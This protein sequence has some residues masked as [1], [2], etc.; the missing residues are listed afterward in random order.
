MVQPRAYE[1]LTGPEKAAVF[2]LAA[3]PEH[4]RKVFE[5]LEF[6][7]IREITQAM[8]SL[9]LIPG[10]VVEAALREFGERCGQTGTLIG[11]Y[12]SAERLL[13][14]FLDEDK[15]QIIME[16][17]RG[18]AGRTLWD[19]LGNVNEAVLAAYL[20]NEYP[21]TIAVVLSKVKPEHAARVLSVLPDEIA[22]E[23][24]MRM[25]RME[26]VQKEIIKEVEK[27]LRAEFMTNLARTHGRDNHEVMAEI[28][29]YLDRGTE[30]RLI[31]MLEERNKES[32][33]KVRAAMFTFEDL[34]RLD[35][36]GIQTLLRR[37]DQSKLGIALKGASEPVR[38]LFF[39]NMSERAAKL[40][41]DDM[42][43]AGPVRVRDVEDAQMAMIGLAKDLAASGEIYL[44]ET[45]EE[46]M[47]Y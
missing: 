42:E 26:V 15:V 45:K 25:L 39:A 20:K 18:P 36:A 5:R 28:F 34:V 43:M 37:A 13:S 23:S 33:D 19:K 8:S 4:A 11:S 46:E 3:G 16:E 40:L 14:R 2:M 6:D 12:E 30:T 38:E 29:N 32:A 41:R 9:G 21:Q 7:E 22:I 44:A 17:I 47:I 31:E 35:A 10:E 24:V 1:S 27:T